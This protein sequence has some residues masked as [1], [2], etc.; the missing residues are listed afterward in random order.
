MNVTITKS[1]TNIRV[2]SPF[3]RNFVSAAKMIGGKWASPHWVFDVRDED[4]VRDLCMEHYG[5]DGRAT[6]ERVTL[7]ATFPGGVGVFGD[8]I[9]L[10]GR[11]IASAFGRDSGAKIG[12]GVVVLSGGFASGGSMK[13]WKT[14]IHE[15]TVVLVR[16][17]PRALADRLLADGGLDQ[18]KAVAVAIEPEAPAIDRDALA[19][20]R[21]RLVARVA[22]IESILAS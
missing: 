18:E 19:K 16:D 12:S 13:N 5:E 4:R 22:E 20:E 1:P 10:A 9:R 6:T 11:E 7:R 3:N 2:A 8:S 21:E 17:V 15:D 14:V